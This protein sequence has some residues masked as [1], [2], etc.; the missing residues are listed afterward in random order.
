V[1]GVKLNIAERIALMGIL[2]SESNVVTLRIV[3][4]LQRDL[5]FTEEELKKWKIKNR[6]QPDGRTLFTWDID[7]ANETKDISI[8]EVAKGIIVEQLKRLSSENRLRLEVLD[9]YEKFV[10][11]K[12]Q[13]GEVS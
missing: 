7:F 12:T 5:S 1:I 13:R 10:E 9:L 6:I 8:G 4:D 3:R 11:E 2:P